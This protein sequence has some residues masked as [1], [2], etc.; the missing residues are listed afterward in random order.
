MQEEFIVGVGAGVG[1]AQQ[2]ALRKYVDPEFPRVVPYIEGF[3]NPSCLIGLATGVLGLAFGIKKRVP[4]LSAYG[5]AAL[6]GSIAGGIID[7]ISPTVPAARARRPP[8]VRPR[9]PIVTAKTTLG[10]ARQPVTQMRPTAANSL[11]M[12]GTSVSPT[13]SVDWHGRPSVKA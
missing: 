13:G 3:G 4:A 6:I 12:V 7:T 9:P 1:A 10:P 11:R 5:G 2:V 8:L